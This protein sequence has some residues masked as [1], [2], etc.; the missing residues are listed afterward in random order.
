MTAAAVMVVGVLAFARFSPAMAAPRQQVAGWMQAAG[1]PEE[2]VTL[3]TGASFGAAIRNP[4]GSIEQVNFHD[5]NSVEEAQAAATFAVKQPTTLP[6][7]LALKTISVSDEGNWVV[8]AYTNGAGNKMLSLSQ[9]AVPPPSGAAPGEAGLS[10]H[11]EGSDKDI[12]ANV[13]R[14]EADGVYYELSGT[15]S[16]AQLQ[17]IADSVQ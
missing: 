12:P 7:G 13:I 14:W 16:E 6:D 10:V 11:L 17:T 1:V 2:V 5:V 8:L 3:A 15:F 4:D 9:S